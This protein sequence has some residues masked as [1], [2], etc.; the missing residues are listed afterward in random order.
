LSTHSATF[1]KSIK[2]DAFSLVWSPQSLGLSW[3]CHLLC[4]ACIKLR[5]LDLCCSLPDPDGQTQSPPHM[6]QKA[7]TH[8]ILVSSIIFFYSLSLIPCMHVAWYQ[9]KLKALLATCMHLYCELRPAAVVAI[10]PF[11]Q[12]TTSTCCVPC[13]LTPTTN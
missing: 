1:H 13:K 5:V 2:A 12:S 10:F 4:H 11:D 7:H 3:D 8:H 9:T 6:K